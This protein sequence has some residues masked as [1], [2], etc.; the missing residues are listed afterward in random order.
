MRF[1][2]EKN[3]HRTCPCL[4]VCLFVCSPD[5]SPT[6]ID[7]HDIKSVLFF[8]FFCLNL[9]KSWLR[10]IRK[11]QNQLELSATIISLSRFSHT[12]CAALNLRKRKRKERK[13]GREKEAKGGREKRTQTHSHTHSLSRISQ[14]K[15][16]HKKGS[17]EQRQRQRQTEN[18]KKRNRERRRVQTEGDAV[19]IPVK[20]P[21]DV[22]VR[23]DV[24]TTDRQTE[25]DKRVYLF[26][27]RVRLPLAC[28][29]TLALYFMC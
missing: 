15:L 1:C 28:M 6:W 9:N 2:S 16:R 12:H 7:F 13:T 25:T 18:E 23:I 14:H 19:F 3:M 26:R 20:S 11:G 29:N 21:C 4:F 5:G 10:V 8:L 17:R 27:P 24:N 22:T